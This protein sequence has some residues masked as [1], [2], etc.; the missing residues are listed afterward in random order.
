MDTYTKASQIERLGSYTPIAEKKSRKLT[1]GLQAQP[2]IRHRSA[3]DPSVF[4]SAATWVSSWLE[5]ASFSDLNLYSVSIG[6]F[7]VVVTAQDGCDYGF[8]RGNGFGCGNGYGCSY[9]YNATDRDQS[10]M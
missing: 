4:G 7:M 10:S 3:P 2:Q 1:V 9:C 8:G 6:N 5:L